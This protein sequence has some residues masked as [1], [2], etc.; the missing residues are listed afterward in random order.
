MNIK[1]HHIIRYV[2]VLSWLIIVSNSFNLLFAQ[3]FIPNNFINY[4]FSPKNLGF[5]TPQ[6]AEFTKYNNA[7][8]N[9][10]NGLLDLK[11]PLLDFKDNTFNITIDLEYLS[12]GFKPGRSPTLVGNNWGLKVGGVITRNICGSPDDV[13]GFKES[14][15]TGKYMLDGLLVAIRDNRCRHYS[16][17]DLYNLNIATTTQGTP[18]VSG[19]LEY[20]YAPDIFNFS[21]GEHRGYFFIN[22]N[23]KVISSLGDGYKIDISSLSIQEYST[24]A[25]PTNSTIKITTPD[26]YIYEFGGDVSYLEYNIPN[27]PKG[28]KIS[29]V[30]IIS[31]HLKTICNVN[32]QR[33][34]QFKY[35]QYEQKNKYNLFLLNA[36]N[37]VTQRI[38]LGGASG[39][40]PPFVSDINKKC[41]L[42]ED[43][44]ITPIIKEITIDK[45]HITFRTGRPPI[46]FWGENNVEDLIY[47]EE[48][49]LGYN[50]T[51]IKSITFDYLRRGKYFFMKELKI[52]SQNTLP[53]VYSFDYNLNTNLPDPLTIGIDHWGFW[54]GSYATNE[55]AREY[56]NNINDRKH[57][58]TK[59]CDIAMLNK[60]THPT[61]GETKITYEYNRYNYWKVKCDDNISWKVN[62]S[63][64][65]IPYGGV[66]VKSITNYDPWSK[67]EIIRTFSYITP[68]KGAGSGIIGDLPKYNIPVETLVYQRMGPNYIDKI[69]EDVWSISSNT[70]GKVHNVAEFHIGY[71]D[72]SESFN[73]NSKIYYHFS[74]MI[75]MPDDESINGKIV[76]SESISR[77][78]NK[79]QL[80]D[81]FGLYNSNDLSGYRGKLITKTT[82]S[83]SRK[84]LSTESY[85]YNTNEAVDNYEVS[86][87]STSIGLAA[88]RIYTTPCRLVE[89]SQLDENQVLITKNYLYKEKNLIA[90]KKTVK[91]NLDTLVLSYF[92]PFD[93]SSIRDGVDNVSDLIQ[94]NIINEPAL[95]IKSIRKNSS[96]G[97]QVLSGIKYNYGKFN[98]QIL[99]KSLSELTLKESI[100]FDYSLINSN[101]KKK[102]EY[103]KYD[104]YGNIISFVKNSLEKSV[105]LWS[106]N[107]QYPVAEIKGATYDQVKAALCMDPEVLS[108]ESIPNMKLINSLRIKLP[109]A[110]VSTYTFQ[111]LVG[112]LT[113]TNPQG[114]I[115]YYN[116]D[117]SGRLAQVYLMENNIKKI[118]EVHE[119]NVSKSTPNTKYYCN[120]TLDNTALGGDGTKVTNPLEVGT[121]LPP[122]ATVYEYNFEGWFDGQTKVTIVPNDPSLTLKARFSKIHVVDIHLRSYLR[123]NGT[124]FIMLEADEEIIDSF[125]CPVKLLKYS[126]SD[127][128][129]VTTLLGTVTIE[130]IDGSSSNEEEYG[131]IPNEKREVVYDLKETPTWNAK[132]STYYNSDKSEWDICILR[133]E[134]EYAYPL[135]L[136]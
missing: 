58:N 91:S 7:N 50:I 57:V 19:D 79:F 65:S 53:D 1:N 56:L 101:F 10:Y 39:Y 124:G 82:Y 94:L 116:Y 93:R 11:I 27:N 114:I 136:K 122:P 61:K 51:L 3:D 31:W 89:E 123:K 17:A 99:K 109:N 78:F 129:Q 119:Y 92:Y 35:K 77:S 106:Y 49:Q 69:T 98:N 74:S 4:Y 54:N 18:Y 130:L 43:T 47:L 121:A 87:L 59:I 81:K 63:Q 52:N 24:S 80:L 6:T 71:S 133:F 96:K 41:I 102:E 28:T 100:S 30:H 107:G 14:S 118:I 32:S 125:T 29:P 64:S 131:A 88:N 104:N 8:I 95:L 60:I 110:S 135:P 108:K 83:G 38:W 72:V 115:T 73:D 37:Q 117:S 66:R 42:I 34:V 105:Y 103:L 13:K 15:T 44:L 120:V 33:K 26:G 40:Y 68:D 55:D 90:E 9:Y 21:F 22:N 127:I 16:K 76:Q 112:M 45:T 46:S 25:P 75:D 5:S 20:D 97:T 12:D 70:I 2:I 132:K 85:I 86:I 111:P 48:I 36:Y 134:N 128:E 23:G 62:F 113:S 67:K 126:I 84:K